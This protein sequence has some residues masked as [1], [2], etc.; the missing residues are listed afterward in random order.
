MHRLLLK[1]FHL[2]T[3]HLFASLDGQE[4]DSFPLRRKEERS[5]GFTSLGRWI[6]TKE[7]HQNSNRFLMRL[8][9]NRVEEVRR[10]MAGDR[11]ILQASEL[12]G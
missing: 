6:R 10:L 7:N 3:L 1:S 8:K 12:R 9:A 2:S 11:E 4:V 5:F